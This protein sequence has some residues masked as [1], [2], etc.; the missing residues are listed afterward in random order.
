MAKQPTPQGA[1]ASD[2]VYT[3]ETHLSAACEDTRCGDCWFD[4]D[5]AC[6]CHPWS[7]IR[8]ETRST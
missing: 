6:I 3:S 2:V 1:D 4:E 8:P 5:C 7:T